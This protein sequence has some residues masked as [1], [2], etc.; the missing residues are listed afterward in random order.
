M[1]NIPINKMYIM[2]VT[3]SLVKKKVFQNMCYI[4]LSGSL[5]LIAV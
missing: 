3:A 2:F 5:L 4:I 1:H